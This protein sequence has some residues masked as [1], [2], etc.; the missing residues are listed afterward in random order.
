MPMARVTTIVRASGKT[1]S[2]II[3]MSTA[4]QSA[5]P[6]YPKGSFQIYPLKCD[7]LYSFSDLIFSHTN[8][9]FS[10]FAPMVIG[11]VRRISFPSVNS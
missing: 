6:Q 5:C 4:R 9:P 1:T 3:T 8:S 10:D 7:F 11:G 2:A